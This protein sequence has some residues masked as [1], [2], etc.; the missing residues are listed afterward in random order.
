MQIPGQGRRHLSRKDRCKPGQGSREADLGG[1]ARQHRSSISKR[2]DG[3]PGQG[4]DL[5]MAIS[6]WAGK[7]TLVEEGRMQTDG[8]GEERRRRRDGGEQM[9]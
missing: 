2:T 4:A 3:R 1:Q 5:G 7:T 8:N 6:I 9:A